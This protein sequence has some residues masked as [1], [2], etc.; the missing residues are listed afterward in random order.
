MRSALQNHAV[1]RAIEYYEQQGAT[2]VLKLG[3]PY[4]RKAGLLRGNGKER[5]PR[6]ARW[7]VAREDAVER[8]EGRGE[9]E[10]TAHRSGEVG[11]AVMGTVAA[12]PEHVGQHLVKRLRSALKAMK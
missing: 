1:D 3:K 4:D 5:G 12:R 7:S 8:V 9:E 11:E 10:G 2:E 6:E